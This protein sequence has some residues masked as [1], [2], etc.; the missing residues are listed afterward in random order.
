MPSVRKLSAASLPPSELQAIVRKHLPA[1]FKACAAD[2]E[3]IVM[4]EKSFGASGGE[5]F[6]LGC[7]LKYAARSGKTVHIT[8]GDDK[9]APR[10]KVKAIAVE[11]IYRE[12]PPS[13]TRRKHGRPS[14][15]QR[16]SS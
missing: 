12:E 15:P 11:A 9:T 3:T 8:C 13:A 4:H 7:A 14:G 10:W 2:A 16:L 6:L 5:L 1:W